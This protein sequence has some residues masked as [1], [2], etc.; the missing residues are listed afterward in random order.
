MSSSLT[1][2][3][4]HCWS[5]VQCPMSNVRTKRETLDIGL[6]TLDRPFGVWCNASI[7]VLG[8]RGDSS[9]LS[10]PTNEKLRISNCEMRIFRMFHHDGLNLKSEIRN[11][12]FIRPCSLTEERFA[13]NESGTGSSPV[14]GSN[15]RASLVGPCLLGP[16]ASRPPQATSSLK[17]K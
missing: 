11:S 10:T 5:K 3:T 12:K 14:R 16:R 8:T 1:W 4:K 7:R 17:Q 6:E 9:I 15:L 2:R 13:S